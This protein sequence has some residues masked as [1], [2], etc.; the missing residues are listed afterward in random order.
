MNNLVKVSDLFTLK[1]GVN[2][3]LINLEQ[4]SSTDIDAIPFVSR[5][6]Q[7]NGVSAFVYEMP[8][9][10]PNP[11]HTLSVA[12]SGSVLSTFYQP[13]SYYSGRDLY[14]LIPQKDF[15]AIEMLFYAKYISA[16]KYRYN[17]GRQANKTLKD[18]LIPETISD[19]LLQY[20][21]SFKIATQKSII[22]QPINSNK[23]EF[24][25][26]NWKYFKYEDIFTIKKGKRL[27]KE[28]FEEGVTPFIGAIDSNN[29]YRDFI[30]Q[31]P[32]HKG[33]TITINYNGSV[34]EAFYQPNSFWASDDVNVLYPKFKFNKYIAMF[35]LPIIRKEKFRFNYGR[36]WEMDT[37]KK[38]I[39][40][41]PA[42]HSGEI[43]TVF[44]ENYIKSL[45]YSKLL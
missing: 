19:N 8:T 40:K 37:M 15:S 29:G 44:M 25:M 23:I 5:T 32:I 36:K 1:Y 35:L 17:Y 2:L 18:I 10:E 6:E 21:K 13:L 30:G 22:K 38:S 4:C 28:D 45:N 26:S 24:D 43:D 16:N 7:N 39:I 42:T 12:V 3:E 20:L 41:L 31:A 11:A 34:G 27:I 9:I 14:V 33:N